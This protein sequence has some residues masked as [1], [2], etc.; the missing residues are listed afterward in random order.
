MRHFANQTIFV[1]IVGKILQKRSNNWQDFSLRSHFVIIYMSCDN[2]FF[3]STSLKQMFFYDI[4]LSLFQGVYLCSLKTTNE[5]KCCMEWD[6]MFMLLKIKRRTACPVPDI[7]MFVLLSSSIILF[8]S[9]QLNFPWSRTSTFN[10]E[11]PA[12]NISRHW[13]SFSSLFKFHVKRFQPLERFSCY[14]LKTQ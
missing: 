1:Y 2:I 5:V 10:K 4:T 14:N 7:C 12:S 8:K 11:V 6:L 13:S 9:S 3:W